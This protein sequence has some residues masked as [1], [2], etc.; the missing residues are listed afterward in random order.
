MISGAL[1]LSLHSITTS[2]Q[3]YAEDGYF[4]QRFIRVKDEATFNVNGS[5]IGLK[6]SEIAGSPFWKNDYSLAALYKNG[7]KA[8]T[9]P[10][11]INFFTNEI[12]FLKGEEEL[13]LA[14]EGIN[15]IVFLSPGDTTSFIRNVPNLFVNTKKVDDFVQVLNTGRYQLLKY[16]KK[17]LGTA[18]SAMSYKR[19]YFSETN[20]YFLKNL[21]KIERVKKLDDKNILSF[22]P[23]SK[24]FSDWIK[25]NGIDFK[26]EKDIISFLNYYNAALQSKD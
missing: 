3:V 23:L 17:Q 15:E 16:T 11:K 20:Y 1:S 12:Y 10:V 22:L 18:D 8:A 4:I 13:V 21:E 7:K 24:T 26:K 9:A 14:E 2:A 5:V 19:Y 25:T 6:Y